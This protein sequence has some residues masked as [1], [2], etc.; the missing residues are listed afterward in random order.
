MPPH[1]SRVTRENVLEISQRTAL[2]VREARKE[3]D[4]GKWL[5]GREVGR[6]GPP[7]SS[8]FSFLP[9]SLER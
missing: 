6:E 7:G 9:G 8:W 5:K 3:R 1:E 2:I 4:G